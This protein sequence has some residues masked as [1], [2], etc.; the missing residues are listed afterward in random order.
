MA[1]KNKILLNCE[2]ATALVEKKRD[3]KLEWSE[4]IGLWIHLAYC[5]FC[6]LFF[7][8]SRILDQSTKAYAEKITTEQK[9]YKLDPLHKAQLTEAFEKEL[10]K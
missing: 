5:G 7:E 4:R 6:A 2:S 3:K 8:Q 9:S 1:L 10:R